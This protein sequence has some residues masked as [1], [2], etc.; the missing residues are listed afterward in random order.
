MTQF[1]AQTKWGDYTLYSLS[2]NQNS[3][4]EISDL[5]AI[6]VNFWV[7]T[8]HC[9]RQNIVLGYD[10]P[11]EYLAGK[12]YL[13]AVVGPWANRIKHGRFTLNGQVFQLECNEGANHL[14]SASA[15]I[16]NKRWNVEK[17]SKSQLVLTCHISKGEAGFPANVTCKVTYTLTNDNALIISYF[18]Q[19][20]ATAPLN[21]T[22]HSYFNL[23]QQTNILDHTIKINSDSYLHVDD[24]SIPIEFRT[25][26]NT[27]MDLRHSQR[28]GDVIPND[29]DQLRTAKGFDHCYVLDGD[30]HTSKVKVYSA[31][32]GL[33]LTVFTD[34]IGIQFY[35]GN[36]LTEEQGRGGQNYNSHAGLCLETQCFPDQ[37]NM[38]NADACIYHPEETYQHSVIYQVTSL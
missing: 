22:Q 10:Q 27:P 20:D 25:V 38:K 23:S 37:V 36:F 35:S 11:D 32:T 29:Y 21:L 18:A 3:L 17:H 31:D 8:K 33:Q 13:G 7:T 26:E 30:I 24:T 5:G 1:N 28:I 4:I 9:G 19:T 14:H 2:N 34:Q 6:I 15:N 12:A 16:G